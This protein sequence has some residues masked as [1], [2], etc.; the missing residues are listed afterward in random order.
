MDAAIA[1]SLAAQAA[2][3][4]TTVRDL[5]DRRYR[6]AG[7]PRPAYPGEPRIVAAGPPLTVPDGHCHFLGGVVDGVDAVRAAVREHVDR[8][9]DVVKVMASGGMMTIGTDLFGAQFTAEELRAAVE[10]A[11]AAGLRIAR[12]LPLRGGCPPRRR[13]GCR[14]PRARH[15]A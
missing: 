10:A 7:R 6:T 3:G 2:A 1:R 9:V 12:A 13:G 8:G 4:V 15:S 5:G 14:R 11:H